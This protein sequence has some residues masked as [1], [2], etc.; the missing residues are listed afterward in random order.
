MKKDIDY[1]NALYVRRDRMEPLDRF[2]IEALQKK[3]Q[4]HLQFIKCGNLG[5]ITFSGVLHGLREKYSWMIPFEF[6]FDPKKAGEDGMPLIPTSQKSMLPFVIWT[7][8][9]FRHLLGGHQDLVAAA[10]A[11]AGFIEE[12]ILQGPWMHM[13]EF[14]LDKEQRRKII[15]K[16]YRALD[17]SFSQASDEDYWD[18]EIFPY[19]TKER[20][21][22]WT[23]LDE[24]PQMVYDIKRADEAETKLLGQKPTYFPKRKEVAFDRC[25]HE[26]WDGTCPECES[27]MDSPNMGQIHDDDGEFYAITQDCSNADC[28]I[29]LESF[30]DWD[31]TEFKVKK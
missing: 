26:H 21:F 1:F 15:H 19:V 13:G 18:K 3:L 20:K 22:F 6:G 9:R 14:K 11:A 31:R 5:D 2:A 30:Y 12:D 24:K 17:G 8:W 23:I 27:K 16:F 29:V 25:Y 10:N 28:K 7:G 4:Y